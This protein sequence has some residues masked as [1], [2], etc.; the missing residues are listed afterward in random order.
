MPIIKTEAVILKSNNYRE[1]SKII[2]FYTRSHGKLKGIAKGVRSTKTKWGGALQSMAM[3][4]IMFYY[5]ENRTLHLVSGAEQYIS[6]SSIYDDFDKLQLGYRM[7]ELVNRTTEE[8]QENAQIFNLLAD[9]LQLLN[10]A[11]KNYVNVLFNFELRLLNLLGFKVDMKDL[12][13]ANIESNIQ[14]Q[15][16]YENRFSAGDIKAMEMLWGGDGGNGEGNFNPFMSLNI[17]KSQ[18]SAMEKFFENYLRNHIA[19]AGFSN[20][21]KV[22]NSREMF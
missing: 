16:F 10:G 18:E 8:Y 17:S 3:L 2:T 4:N 12:P 6:I 14:N 5:K 21:K 19:D 1:T 9:S 22:F 15:Y 11:T 20:A 13:G 7:V